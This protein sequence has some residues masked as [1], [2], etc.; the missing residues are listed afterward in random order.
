MAY[1]PPGGWPILG[2]LGA[3]DAPARRPR[4]G[5]LMRMLVLGGTRFLSH[6]IAA[7]AV[8]RGHDVVCAAR[9]V[10][11]RVPVGARLVAVDRDDPD[12][13]EPLRGERCQGPVRTA[14]GRS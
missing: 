12:G 4:Q 14:P 7:D 9:G 11:G 1:L 2:S 10:S 6:A 3:I 8:R 13:L 5:G